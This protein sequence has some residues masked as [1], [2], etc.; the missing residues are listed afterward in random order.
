MRIMNLIIKKNKKWNNKMELNM[1]NLEKYLNQ[2]KE[3][4]KVAKLSKMKME[5][6]NSLPK[7]IIQITKHL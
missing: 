4:Y 5:I 2:K 1:Y 7:V 3:N 6:L